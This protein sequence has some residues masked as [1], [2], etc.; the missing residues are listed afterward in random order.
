MSQALAPVF[1]AL[2][3]DTRWA[4]L[5]R[6]GEAPASASALAREFP[7]SRQAIVKHLDVLRAAGLVESE[8][9]GRELVHRALGGRLSDVARELERIGQTWDARLT[10]IKKLAEG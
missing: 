5:A 1:A 8:Q 9:Q 10:R 6:L 3:D 4:L 7:I 2:G